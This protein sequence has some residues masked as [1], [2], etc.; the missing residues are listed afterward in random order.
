MILKAA[1]DAG[2]APQVKP[3]GDARTQHVVSTG[4]PPEIHSLYTGEP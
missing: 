4:Q 3:A 1:D 2:I